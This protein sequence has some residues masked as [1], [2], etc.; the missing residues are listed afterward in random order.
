MSTDDTR[1]PPKPPAAIGGKPPPSE[2]EEAARRAAEAAGLRA[3]PSRPADPAADLPK[4]GAADEAEALR[5][6]LPEDARAAAEEAAAA[7]GVP[8][9]AWLG[10]LLRETGPGDLRAPAA[11]A[12]M[13]TPASSGGMPMRRV[14]VAQ[15]APGRFQTRTALDAEAIA[16]LAQSIL[17][18]GVLQPILV[19]ERA[20]GGGY[21]IIAG[22]RRWRA[23]GEAGL[24]EA[25]VIVLE[26]ADR[27]AMEIAL[28]EN[29]QR[30]DLTALEEA[31]GYRRL[32]EEL[33]ET[34]E[35]LAEVVG[36]SRSHV[37]NTLRLLRL[38]EPIKALLA[39]GKL[40]AGH[41]RALL[42]A[43][44]PEALARHALAAGLSVRDTER[45]A[46]RAAPATAP[47]AKEPEVAGIEA[48]LS[49]LLGAAVK[50]ALRAKGE[51]GTLTIRFQGL[52]MLR[53]LIERLRP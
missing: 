13:A 31:E 34:Q 14:P 6:T 44:D 1:G 9:S 5:A 3:W 21:E 2:A 12:T 30:H 17:A 32:T 39:E 25:P 18:R 45:M 7:A 23:A 15:L 26:V 22:E 48:E 33:G 37:A 41:A 52:A 40:S 46:Q 51:R 8:L 4:A 20:A 49:R 27:E 29:L 19:R 24:A 28:V 11:D 50:I 36:K 10:R 16:A 47:P 43:A 53:E 38:P 42:A 35:R